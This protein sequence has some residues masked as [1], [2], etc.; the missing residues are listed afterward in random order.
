[1]PQG[2]S[3]KNYSVAI[4]GQMGDSSVDTHQHPLPILKHRLE[5]SQ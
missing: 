3:T 5:Q 2:K 4:Q 1:M